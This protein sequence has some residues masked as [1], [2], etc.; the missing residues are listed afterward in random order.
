MSKPIGR[1]HAGRR[2]V[3]SDDK[4]TVDSMRLVDVTREESLLKHVEAGHAEA[5]RA[6][7][8]HTRRLITK[9]PLVPSPRIKEHGD[10]EEVDQTFGFLFAIRG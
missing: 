8:R 5:L 10:E 1:A 3:R 6:T 2:K 9:D 7:E 4:H